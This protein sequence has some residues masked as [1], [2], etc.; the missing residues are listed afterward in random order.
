MKGPPASFNSAVID[1]PIAGSILA[2]WS[3]FKVN[4][5]LHVRSA[6]EAVM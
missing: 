4:F 6:D 2:K 3:S 1:L 5:E